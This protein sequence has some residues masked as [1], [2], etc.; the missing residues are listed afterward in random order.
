MLT[1]TPTSPSPCSVA[2]PSLERG[3]EFGCEPLADSVHEGIELKGLDRC[4]TA[5]LAFPSGSPQWPRT[6]NIPWGF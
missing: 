5:A 1:L 6:V 4:R 3:L 2:G